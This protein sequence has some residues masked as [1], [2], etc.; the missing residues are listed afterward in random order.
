MILLS[1]RTRPLQKSSLA[2]WALDRFARILLKE[3]ESQERRRPCRRLPWQCFWPSTSAKWWTIDS[4]SRLPCGRWHRGGLLGF[5]GGLHQGANLVLQGFVRAARSVYRFPYDLYRN[6]LCASFLV[7]SFR[8]LSRAFAADDESF[9]ISANPGGSVDVIAAARTPAQDPRIPFPSLLGSRSQDRICSTAI[10]PLSVAGAVMTRPRLHLRP[11]WIALLAI[12]GMVSVTDAASACTVKE[13]P[14]PPASCCAGRPA[15][16]CSCCP[17]AES[18]DFAPAATSSDRLMVA[19]PPAARL[20]RSPSSC[21]CRSN[22]PAAPARES[23]PRSSEDRSDP[24]GG[25][26]LAG[27]AVVARPPAAIVRPISAH[28][29]PPKSPLYLRTSRLLI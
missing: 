19:G 17:P 7:G 27:L 12:A 21:A 11:F 15:S 16:D 6:A 26:A 9:R 24:V 13:V 18:A 22:E 25:Q 2:V 20:A 28:P 14:A 23:K 8:A 5:G 3:R 29:S 4:R 10:V 1:G